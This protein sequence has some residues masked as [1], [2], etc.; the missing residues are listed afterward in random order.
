MA[1][2]EGSATTSVADTTAASD[3]RTPSGSTITQR[4]FLG[5]CDPI[6]CRFLASIDDL[7][8]VNHWLPNASRMFRALER[9]DLFFFK[10]KGKR[11]HIA[12]FGFFDRYERLPA[13][14]AWDL[15]GVANAERDLESMLTSI[16]G[17]PRGRD[18]ITGDFDIGCIVI[19]SPVFFPDDDLVE[20][21]SDWARVGIQQG[22]GY[23][24]TVGEGARVLR[25]C[26]ERAERHPTWNVERIGAEP[27]VPADTLQVRPRFG[28]GTFDLAVAEAYRDACATTGSRVTPTLRAVPIRPPGRGGELVVD[29]GL[30]LRRDL[31]DL[32]TRGHVTVTPDH[33]FLVG[34]SLAAAYGDAQEYYRLSGRRIELPFDPA[35]RPDREA[36]AHHYRSIYKA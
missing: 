33:E 3:S 34:E 28:P 26:L 18:S 9:G 14:R 32:Y 20:P 8:E 13:W 2:R 23:D 22:M 35:S 1:R 6:R 30:Y 4:G 29:N 10:M 11:K 15:F 7:R 17:T 36:L 16:R 31:C 21:P 27:P 25:D 12:G 5:L 19:T 24:L